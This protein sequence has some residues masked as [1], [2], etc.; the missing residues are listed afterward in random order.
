[1]CEIK[2]MNEVLK[3]IQKFEVVS[4]IVAN[5]H[6]YIYADIKVIKDDSKR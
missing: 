5:I 3:F 6:A 2:R 4:R 1:M